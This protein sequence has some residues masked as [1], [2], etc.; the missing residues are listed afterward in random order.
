MRGVL[1]DWAD[2]HHCGELDGGKREG[3]PPV[4][5]GKYVSK[6][7]LLPPDKSKAEKIRCAVSEHQRHRWFGSLKSSQALAQS[8]F[9]A[10]YAFDR[11]DL[12]QDVRTECWRPAFFEDHKG[13]TLEFEHEVDNLNEPRPTSV[14]VLLS[15]PE[16]RVSI[17]C[18]F[19][20]QEFGTCSRPRLGPRD[21]RYAEEH[22]NGKY[23]VQRQRQSRCTLTEIGIR[24]WEHLPHLFDWSPDRDLVPCPFKDVYQLARNALVAALTPDGRPNPSIGHALVVYDARNPKF[25][26]GGAAENQ[27]NQAVDACR[28]PGLLRRLSWQRLMTA[29]SRAPELAYLVQ[30]I[31]QKYGLEPD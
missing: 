8:V 21:A 5:A 23:Q 26:N 15:G 29:I 22:C 20:E 30:G 13:W 25:Q 14:D 4:L 2:R 27:W 24:Y 19:T 3:R 16:N 18:K 31:S 7:V 6:N 12:L 11:L 9:G 10:I 28:M 17:E 1:W